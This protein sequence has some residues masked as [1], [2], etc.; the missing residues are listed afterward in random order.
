MPT[1]DRPWVGRY[2]GRVGP[3]QTTRM[4]IPESKE[5]TFTPTTEVINDIPSSTFELM[6]LQFVHCVYSLY[7][8]HSECCLT[9]QLQTGFP[10]R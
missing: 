5:E 6:D 4:F 9:F 1:Y 10:F 3:V 2:R 7:P 8:V